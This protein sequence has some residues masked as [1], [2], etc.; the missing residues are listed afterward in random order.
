M[1]VQGKRKIF[2]R[3]AAALLGVVLAFGIFGDSVFGK[4]D[5]K[6]A[7]Y[8]YTVTFY[9]GNHGNFQGTEM[10][11]VD[12]SVSGSSY[13]ISTDG[14][15]IRISGLCAGDVVGLDAAMEGAV[16][17]DED[18]RYYVKGIRVSGRDNST[19]DASAFRVEEDRD[20]VVAY[21]IRGDLTSYVVHYQDAQ[22]NALAPSRTYYGN[23]GDRPRMAYLYIE[24]YQPQA[25]NLTKTLLKNEAENVFAFVY[26]RIPAGGTGG[27]GTGGTG[28][29]TG[30]GGAGMGGA[31]TGTGG[32]GGDGTGGA[33][34]AGGQTTGAGGAAAGAGAGNAPGDTGNVTN[35]DDGAD[36]GNADDGAAQGGDAQA[37]GG[38]QGDDA[39]MP[40]DGND[41]PQDE[42]NLDD[43]ETPLATFDGE[44]G[45]E[46][47]S[48]FR[49]PVWA[50]ICIAV[51]GAVAV[52]A[53][54]WVML[55][56]RKK[57]RAGEE[58]HKKE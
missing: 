15:A 45:Q 50:S 33:G 5:C 41:G 30:T 49:F 55:A 28:G 48:G 32:T 31:G 4:M 34:A 54:L 8:F 56:A 26:T 3:G 25:Y 6:A 29:G 46:D 43:A 7:E 14:S 2:L 53:V 51:A 27:S 13:E 11:T 58:E 38:D 17:L 22:G 35:P 20:Y 19:V 42:V 9:P 18:S 40:D 24:G 37:P 57:A 12:N 23:V 21:G 10:V 47:S 39:Q 44:N 52:V 36:A 16:E 1:S